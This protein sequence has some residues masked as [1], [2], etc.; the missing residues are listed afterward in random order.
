M[1]DQKK[2]ILKV[3]LKTDFFGSGEAIKDLLSNIKTDDAEIDIIHTGV[4]AISERD[5]QLAYALSLAKK[6]VAAQPENGA[7]LDTIGWIYYKLGNY[8]MALEYIKKS[9]D[10]REDGPVVIEHLG[11]VYLKLGYPDEAKIYWRR[12]LQIDNDNEELK[13]KIEAN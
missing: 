1:A 9:L 13:R 3:I 12:A 2:K 4:G 6:A 5:I 10:N 8:D 11:D 7:Y